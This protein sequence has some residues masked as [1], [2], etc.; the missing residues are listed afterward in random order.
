[1]SKQIKE[2]MPKAYSTEIKHVGE[3]ALERA[4]IQGKTSKLNG[5]EVEWLDIELPVNVTGKARGNCI[6]L[7]GKD[8]DN[9]YILCEL[10]FRR[11]SFDNG[12]PEEAANQIKKYLCMVKE[13]YKRLHYHRQNGSLINWEAVALGK[14]RL[15]VAA[16]SRYWNSWLGNR[17]KGR[18]YKTEGVECY[19][20]NLDQDEFSRQKGERDKYSPYMPES[21][22][23]WELID[24]NKFKHC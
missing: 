17:R 2:N 22:K 5:F 1:M 19:S 12:N 14:T 3:C 9:N 11:R 7:I 23:E 16:N 21:G 6:D 10:K 13:Y 4:I 15:V 24:M 8:S 20:I 18:T